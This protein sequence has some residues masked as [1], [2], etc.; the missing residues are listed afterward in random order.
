MFKGAFS[1]PQPYPSPFFFKH[2]VILAQEVESF[3][4]GF[5][6]CGTCHVQKLCT[7]GEISDKPFLE[8]G[9]SGYQHL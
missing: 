1:N 3:L 5:L 8:I 2:M 6:F 9:N 4:E 7:L